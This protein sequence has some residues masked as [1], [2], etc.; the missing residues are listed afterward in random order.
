MQVWQILLDRHLGGRYFDFWPK[1][2]I[3]VTELSIKI[4]AFNKI[5]GLLGQKLPLEAHEIYVVCSISTHE[6]ET[7]WAKQN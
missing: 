4:T 1:R 6:K 2:V 5:L 7:I 3:G